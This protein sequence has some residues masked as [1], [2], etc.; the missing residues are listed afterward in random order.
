MPPFLFRESAVH[1]INVVAATGRGVAHGAIT[2]EKTWTPLCTPQSN[3]PRL[4]TLCGR[5]LEPAWRV[6]AAADRT[7]QGQRVHACAAGS[8]CNPSHKAALKGSEPWHIDMFQG[9]CFVEKIDA[10]VGSHKEKITKYIS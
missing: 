7:P 8:L 10:R 3:G 9:P 6:Q 5:G 1:T 2:A 4:V